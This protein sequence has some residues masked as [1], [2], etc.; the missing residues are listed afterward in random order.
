MYDI[1]RKVIG[2]FD[3]YLVKVICFFKRLIGEKSILG[4]E[5]N[6]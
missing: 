2:W 1:E 4:V 5:F 3:Q 6:V